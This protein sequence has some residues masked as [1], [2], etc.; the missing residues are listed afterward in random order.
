MSQPI[1]EVFE[2]V[3]GALSQLFVLSANVTKYWL[4]VVGEK[5]ERTLPQK[6]LLVSVVSAH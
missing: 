1:N 4:V 5:C 3:L 6:S 2:Y